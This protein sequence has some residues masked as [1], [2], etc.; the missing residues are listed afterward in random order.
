MAVKHGWTR[1]LR[2]LGLALVVTGCVPVQSSVSPVNIEG[3]TFKVEL[4]GESDEESAEG[5]GM[6]ALNR[7]AG[8]ICP[9]GFRTLEASSSWN[10]LNGRIYRYTVQCDDAARGL[11]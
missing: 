7:V 4:P 11:N 2:F 6:G 9:Q 5:T 3:K 1:I 8:R 10:P